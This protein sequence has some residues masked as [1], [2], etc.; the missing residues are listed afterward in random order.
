[1]KAMRKHTVAILTEMC[2]R[3]NTKFEDIDFNKERWFMKHSWNK[4]E[5]EDFIKWITKYL[6]E[7]KEARRE[8]MNFPDKKNIK[9]VVKFFVWN[10]GWK[11]NIFV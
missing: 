3:V 1:M 9:K 7:N 4:E 2:D 6:T 5:Q 10:Y 11:T 8:M